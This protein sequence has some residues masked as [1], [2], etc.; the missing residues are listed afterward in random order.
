LLL[1]FLNFWLL[2]GFASV[3]SP[4]TSS[5]TSA[6]SSSSFSVCVGVSASGADVSSSA[7]SLVA[8]AESAGNLVLCCATWRSPEQQFAQ[9][10]MN[11]RTTTTMT[12]AKAPTA[13]R[14]F[15]AALDTAYCTY[16]PMDPSSMASSFACFR[17]LISASFASLCIS[18]CKMRLRSFQRNRKQPRYC[19]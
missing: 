19:S 10:F 1:L 2:S 7:T 9:T 16:P 12:Q 3:L 18:T 4:T 5:G 6:G 17:A 14:G 13:I 8:L 15:S 11:T